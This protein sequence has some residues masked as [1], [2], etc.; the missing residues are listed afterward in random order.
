V[1]NISRLLLVLAISAFILVAGGS[2]QSH[3]QDLLK[4]RVGMVTV[5]SQMALDIG[6]KKGFF[7]KYGFDVEIKSLTTGVQA[8]QALAANQVDWS[9]G[10]VEST[11]IASSTHLPFKP[12]SMYA[13]GGDSLGILV[14]KD[15]GIKTLRDLENKRVAVA[16]GTA[17]AQGL[18][19]VLKSLNLPNDAVKR[20]NANF[21]NMGQMLVQGAVDAMVGLEPFL[22]LTEQKMGADGV[23][24]TRLGKYVQGGGFFLISDAWAAAHP[25]KI[26]VAVE[27]LWET[28]KFIRDN[29]KE[30]AQI[31]AATLKADAAVIDA[32]SQWLKFDPL[33]DDFTT[34]SLKATS[35]Y[36]LSEKIIA[37][38]VDIPTFLATAR[39]VEADLKKKRP[40]LLK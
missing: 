40:D 34:S 14:R 39:K 7:A 19:Q 2:K 21:G 18:S 25:D 35:S 28:E 24:L 17:S 8:N 3:A 15:A 27:A 6:Q 37:Q 5:A 31:N 29:P 23:L 13:K 12:Y 11:I 38:E 36:L 1:L 33:L 20:V 22:T 16:S 9:A 10:G 30:A 4:V 26:K 32:S